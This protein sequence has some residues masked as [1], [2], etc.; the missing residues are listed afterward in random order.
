MNQKKM[1]DLFHLF[2]SVF[3]Q[4]IPYI[5]NN[6]KKEA[7]CNSTGHVN[8]VVSFLSF[9]KMVR[10][11]ESA[12]GRCVTVLHLRLQSRTANVGCSLGRQS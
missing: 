3:I 10:V 2:S 1:R 11:S 9:S 6:I 4:Q 12:Y 7:Q 5:C 8:V